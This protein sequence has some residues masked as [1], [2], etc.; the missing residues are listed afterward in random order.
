[1]RKTIAC[2]PALLSL[3]LVH[4]AAPG[5]TPF[6]L[7][8]KDEIELGRH[9]AGEIEK[10]IRLIDDPE[11]TKYIRNLGEALVNRSSRKG[12]AY[13]FKVVNSPEINAF[14]LPGG[15][16]YVNRGLIETAASQNELAGVLGHEIGHVV[17][18]HGADQAARAGMVQ[19]GLGILGGIL[20]RGSRSTNAQ[21]AA[22]MVAQGV[23]MKFS[24]EAER[25]ADRIAAHMLY[26]ARLRPQGML[27]FFE[28]LAA[29]QQLQPNAVQKF[30][31][32]HPSPAERSHNLA[33][34]IASFPGSSDLPADSADFRDVRKRLAALPRPEVEAAKA[35]AAIAAA[36][37]PPADPEPEVRSRNAERDRE[38]AARFAPI[39]YQA[40]G[41]A[42][43]FDYVTSFDFDGDWRGDNNWHNA[44][45]GRYP[46]KA[47][48]YYA[49]FET[50]THFFVQYAVFHPRDYKGGEKRGALLSE[51]MR[52]GVGL[53][54]QYDPTGRAAEAVMAHENDLEGALVV[55][56]K[57]GPDPAKA[58]LIIVET[59]AHNHFLKYVP[60]GSAIAGDPVL[61][62]GTRPRLFIE[63]KGHGI[64]AWRDDPLQRR[65]AERGFI[66]YTFAG[67][68]QDPDTVEGNSVGYDLA[69]TFDAL[70]ERA[71]SGTNETCGQE[72]DYGI[73]TVR[74]AA[75]AEG[76]ERHI[77]VGVRGSALNGAV[78]APNMSRP[79]WGWFD[80]EDRGR[81]LGEWFL[82][83]AETIR[84]RWKLQV[85]STTY[86]Y[87]PFLGQFRDVADSPT[88]SGASRLH[89]EK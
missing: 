34:L 42:P 6:T 8:E 3:L 39:F 73:V 54:G 51:A 84:R 28:R 20:G 72:H 87:H 83:P 56:E 69:A 7:S 5:Q 44:E 52:I 66:V 60:A 29:L 10:E 65:Q 27:S 86:T 85:L 4:A 76:V 70:W 36:A 33:D 45:D 13:A 59:L 15:F 1:M 82:Q 61:V 22:A 62:E 89:N 57:D 81:P 64:E 67:S 48:V 35:A 79:P 49:V 53:G 14:A 47:Y 25:E 63:S 19:T 16:I 23:F 17:A 37:Q 31:S 38:I 50:R 30:F 77:R 43:R 58:R 75:G 24:R 26:D 21:T 74:F 55:A 32:S 41:P 80:G 68:A 12:I 40:L 88:G 71:R 9:A 11:I 46:L 2:V 18:R 78:G